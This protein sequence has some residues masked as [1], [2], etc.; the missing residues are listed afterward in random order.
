VHLAERTQLE[1]SL[2]QC[3]TRIAAMRLKLNTLGNHPSRAAFERLFH[4]MQGARDQ[5]AEA[6]RRM[7]LEVGG[8]YHEDKE[9]YD[10]ALAALDRVIKDWDKVAG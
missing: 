3:D 2:R 4:Q 7:P 8:L 9:R 1:E 5:V 6:V 10:F